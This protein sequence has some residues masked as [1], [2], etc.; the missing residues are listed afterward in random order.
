MRH[1]NIFERAYVRARVGSFVLPLLP[2][3]PPVHLIR[4][5]SNIRSPLT[6]FAL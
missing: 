3:L 2:L 5:P 6:F 1:A 4:I